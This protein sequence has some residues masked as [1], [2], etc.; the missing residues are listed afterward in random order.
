MKSVKVQMLL[1]RRSRN[2]QA[3]LV[4]R[5]IVGPQHAEQIKSILADTVATNEAPSPLKPD[6]RTIA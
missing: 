4:L 2:G 3:D 6:S 1:L 5:A